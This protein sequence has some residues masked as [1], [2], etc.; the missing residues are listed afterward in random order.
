MFDVGAGLLAIAPPA[1]IQSDRVACIA[2]KPAPTR[3]DG[4][5][6]VQQRAPQ[7]ECG[8][9][10]SVCTSANCPINCGLSQRGGC[11]RSG[12]ATRPGLFRVVG[13]Q[14]P[15][16]RPYHLAADLEALLVETMLQ[17]VQTLFLALFRGVVRQVCC[18]G[19]RALAV[20][21]SRKSRNPRL[22][23]ASWSVR[24]LF[25]FRREA[26]NKVGADADPRYGNAVCAAWTCT[27]APCDCV[28]S[29]TEC[30]RNPIAPA[31]A[32]V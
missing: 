2:S 23:S 29:P 32:G 28:S 16:G 27:P 19:A 24:S 17:R 4:V 10:A 8:W 31:D 6:S 15:L 11:S 5:W 1:L 3:D 7:R 22:R 26:D 12:P 14:D 13:Y 21:K 20:D 9:A 18:R 25:R 30:G